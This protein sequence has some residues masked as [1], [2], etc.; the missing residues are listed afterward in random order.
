MIIIKK[1]M[2][3]KLKES[4]QIFSITL[5]SVALLRRLA[6][7]KYMFEIPIAL[8]ITALNIGLEN[9]NELRK[10]ERA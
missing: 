10:Y 1:K 2:Q 6:K 4:A 8:S 3:E 5:L 9:G 7:S